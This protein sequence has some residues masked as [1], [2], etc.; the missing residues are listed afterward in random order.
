MASPTPSP[1]RAVRREHIE[2]LTTMVADVVPQLQRDIEAV[3]QENA[4]GGKVSDLGLHV[5]ARI[6]ACPV[7]DGIHQLIRHSV[8]EILKEGGCII[9]Q[10][11]LRLKIAEE[12]NDLIFEIDAQVS[13]LD[14]P[15]IAIPTKEYDILGAAKTLMADR[16]RKRDEDDAAGEAAKRARTEQQ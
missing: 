1:I 13:L 16:K 7:P 8:S 4:A 14:I 5:E 12:H 11:S 6:P 3:I 10:H 15:A 9:S 2:I